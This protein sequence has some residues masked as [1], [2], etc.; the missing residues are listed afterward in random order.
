MYGQGVGKYG[1]K[2]KTL[3]TNLG[4]IVH[5]WYEALARAKKLML[6]AGKF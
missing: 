2:T 6:S 4:K 5:C 1:Y 3:N